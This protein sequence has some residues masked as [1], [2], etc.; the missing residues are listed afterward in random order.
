[1]KLA[2]KVYLAT[3]IL[4]TLAFATFAQS[5]ARSDKDP[6][7]TAPTVGTGGSIGGPTGL[8]TVY[9][10]STL[11][12]GEYTFSAA[13]SNYDRDP[14]NVDITSV[15][16]SFQVG[17]TNRVELFFSTDLLKQ[18]KVNSPRNLSGFYLPNSQV[19]IAGRGITSAP[20]IVLS[21]QGPGIS[22]YPNTAI[23]RPTGSPFSQ[24]PFSGGNAGTYGLTAPFFSGPVFGFAA[25]TNAQLGPP[26]LGGNGADNFPG[27]GSVYGSILPGIVLTS[28]SLVTQT[29]AAAGE[30]PGVFTQMPSYLPDAPFLNRQFGE[31]A[32]NEYNAG[33][34]IRLNN[35]HNA[36]G[37]GFIAAYTWYTNNANSFSGFNQLQRGASPGG[38]KGDVSLTAFAD[39]RL[40]TWVNMSANVGY[41]WTSAVKGEFPGGTFTLLDRPDELTGSFGVDFPVNKWFQPIAEFRSLTYVGGRTP[42]AFE[43]NPIDGLVGA[44]VFAT[45]WAGFGFAYR[46][47]FNQQSAKTFDTDQRFSSSV[48]VPCRPGSTNCNPAVIT[49]TFAGIP[50]GFAPSN[51]PNGYILQAFIGRRNK[52]ATDIEN[53]AANINSVNLSTNVIKIGCPDG[54]RSQS[55]GCAD[56]RTVSVSTSA[57]DPEGDVLTYNYTVSGGRVVGTGANVQWDLSGA[58]K[59]TYTITTA[60]DDG[61]GVCGKT[62]TQTVKIEECNDCVQICPTCPSLSVTGPSSSTSPGSTMTFSINGAGSNSV[63]WTVSAGTI[64][65]GQG[66]STITVRTTKEMGGSNVT[67]TAEVNWG[68]SP[69]TC[70]NTAS[71]TAPVVGLPKA[72]MTDEF[73]KQ[74]DDE[75]KARVDNF[76]ILLNNDPNATG[77]IVLYG[78]A[79]EM[80]HRKGQINKAITFRKYDASRVKF[81]EAG[82]NGMGEYTKFWFVP[83]GANAPTN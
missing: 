35:I 11:R 82:D 2:I 63:N 15:P 44:R 49:T 20:A 75:V 48:V 40:A 27:I 23:Y 43:N 83:A 56:S 64:E 47:N 62:N 8:F 71:E 6:R 69:C 78:T 55:G 76:Y 66:T 31:S 24:F 52:R 7:N 26:R 22:Q 13:A 36:V 12:K 10:G 25:G 58:G 39:A 60:V 1:M 19:F 59:G 72:N 37:Y 41:K 65:S 32:F 61:C 29:G 53:Q 42:N 74:K 45:R 33:A 79:K 38:N 28:T 34:K 50:S 17:L 57:S 81:V 3:L 46:Y 67:A 14:G 4:L 68:G 30:G 70:P 80:A 73:G 18:V 5:D 77:Y 54:Y 9:D 16:V 21:P 51:D